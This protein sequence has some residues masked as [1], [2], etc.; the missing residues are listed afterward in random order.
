MRKAIIK[1][2][3]NFKFGQTLKQGEE[4]TIAETPIGNGKVTFTAYKKDLPGLGFGI[5]A[6]EF[7]YT[8]D[9]E[10]DVA[11]CRTS[12][13]HKTIRVKAKTREEAEQLAIDEAG[14]LEFSES[15]AEYSVNSVSEHKK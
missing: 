15:D 14:G 11:V 6:S 9:V 4:V 10:F 3:K 1:K 7:E 5:K 8:E 13:S 12:Y 2:N